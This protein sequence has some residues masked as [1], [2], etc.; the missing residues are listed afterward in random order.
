M[1]ETKSALPESMGESDIA[2]ELAD[3]QGASHPPAAVS[4][5]R[6]ASTGALPVIIV[7]VRFLPNGLVNSITQCPEGVTAQEWFDKL[8]RA[9][10]TTYSPLSG[11]RGAFKILADEFSAL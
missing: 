1:S 9:F 3:T 11:G 6:A 2:A 7:N 4:A 10:P 8:C 5:A